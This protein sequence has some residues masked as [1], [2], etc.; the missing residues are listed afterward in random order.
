MNVSISLVFKLRI[1]I[2]F[3]VKLFSIWR[4]TSKR[5][6]DKLSEQQ[7][8]IAVPPKPLQTL[9]FSCVSWILIHSDIQ[10]AQRK[11]HVFLLFQGCGTGNSQY[12]LRNNYCL[13]INQK[14][15]CF[16]LLS[17]PSSSNKNLL[18]WW[19]LPFGYMIIWNLNVG[20]SSGISCWDNTE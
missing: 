5:P 18:E 9:N 14:L 17:I 10:K 6:L 13:W 7:L 1:P 3:C 16:S 2:H 20:T 15:M 11:V 12:V 8:A 4:Q 19:G